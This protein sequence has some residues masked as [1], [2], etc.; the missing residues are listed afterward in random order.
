MVITFNF[1]LLIFQATKEAY[2]ENYMG[3]QVVK[4]YFHLFPQIFSLYIILITV[5]I[6]V[7]IF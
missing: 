4:K 5:I 2:L 7:N 3:G 6:S 1:M